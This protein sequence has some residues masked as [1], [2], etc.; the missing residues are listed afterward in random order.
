[1]IFG[2]S[3]LERRG[4]V[5]SVRNDTIN[6]NVNV[7]GNQAQN[8]LNDLRK[9]SAD[10]RLELEGLKKGTQAYIDK[11]KELKDV[12]AQQDALK[13]QIGLTAL[14]QKE[15]IQE[16][17]KLKA[18]KGSVIPFSN[19]FKDLQKQ[20]EK[21][22]NRLYDV[23][24]GVTGF[25]SS[26]SKIKDEVKQFGI[27]AAAYLGFE[28]ITNQFT[29]IIKGAG[30][31]SDSLA[32]IQRVTGMT[33]AEVKALN[34][35]LT[36]M[37]TRTSTEGLRNIA[38]VAGKLGVAKNDIYDFVKATDMLV[39]A[40]GDELGDA[41]QITTQLGKIINVFDK[42]DGKVTGEK[43]TS[44]GNA[45]VD[46]ANKGVA[47]GGFIVD[48][49]Q[50]LAGL[51]KTANLGLDAVMGLAAGLEESGQRSESSST[52]IIKVLS[53]IGGDVPK[54]AKVAGKSVEEFSKTLAEKPVEA[55]IQVSEGFTKGKK[56]F[57]DIS[58]AFADAGEDGAKIVSTLGVIG[59]KADWFR[60]KIDGTSD[61]LKNNSQITGAF[62]LK[63]QTL[64][65]T[66]DKLGKDFNKLVTSAAVTD[67]LKSAVNGVSEFIKWL[68]DLPQ[69]IEQNRTSLIV[70]TGVILTYVAAK[71]KATQASLLSRLA[72]ILE[73]AADK[74][75]AVQK[76]ALIIVTR[77][78]SYAKRVLAGDITLAAAAQRIWNAATAATGGI[79]GI[80]I[81]AITAAAAAYSFFASKVSELTAAQRV[82]AELQ[83]R[84]TDLTSD[85][86]AKA[87]SLFK[88]L[89]SSA[90]GYEAKKKLLQELIAINPEYLSGLNM[91]N[92]ATQKGAD[93]MKEYIKNLHE[94]NQEKARQAIIAEKE[95][96]LLETSSEVD[97]SDKNLKLKGHK[98]RL[99]MTWMDSLFDSF[100]SDV[101]TSTDGKAEI[102][103]L[104]D[105]LKILYDDSA[106]ALTDSM[107]KDAGYVDNA[108]KGVVASVARTIKTIK[109][110]ITALD[111]AY[112]T[113]DINNVAALKKNRDDRKKL[114]DELD[115]LEGKQ[116]KKTKAQKQG[117]GEYNQLKKEAE[118][119]KKDLIKLRNDVEANGLEG[120]KEEI[121]RLEDKYKELT[122]KAKKYFAAHITTK[123]EY[124]GQELELERLLD[125]EIDRIIKK[126]MGKQ[127]EAEYAESLKKSAE[128][129]DEQK[130]LAGRNYAAGLLDKKQYE[131][132]LNQLE[133]QEVDN[134]VIIAKDYSS[135]V[136]KA[137]ED[138]KT[139]TKEQEKLTT[140]NLIA[141]AEKR[142]EIIEQEKLAT[143]KNAVLT[144]RPNTDARLIADKAYLQAKF[145]LETQNMDKTSALYE[146]KWN[147]L[148]NSL[149]E[150]DKQHTL[151][152]IEEIMK[153]V[154]YFQDA[155]SSL[156][157]IISNK[158]NKALAEDR[159]RNDTKKKNYKGQL[160]GKLMSQAQYDKK[161]QAL[162]D[163][164]A[165]RE[166]EA[167]RKQAQ[168]EKAMA[169][170][171]AVINTAAAIAKTFVEFGWPLG[172]PMA[173]A[174]A[175]TGG[176]QVAAISS[177]PL[178]EMGTGGLLENGPY[179]K[180][181]DKGL[182]VV[183]PRTGKTEMLLEKDEA[184]MS[185]RAMKDARQ[186][187]VSGT[188]KQIS[189]AL[190]AL[191][192]GVNWA[193]GA[194]VQ[195]PKWR[196][197]RPANINPGVVRM[198]ARGGAVN[199]EQGTGNNEQRIMNNGAANG[200]GDLMAV[201]AEMRGLR[202]DMN[203]WKTKL[204]GEWVIKELDETRDLYDRAKKVSG[205]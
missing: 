178:P 110:Q 59:G 29:S 14:T 46:L 144:S 131:A 55:I 37:D 112:E 18:L 164:Q 95:K 126:R 196:T 23:R 7:N 1:M 155:L 159:K 157:T 168:R 35:E 52:A 11:S 31:L 123:A 86:E 119:Y 181:A 85:E 137:A 109:D 58:K 111:S 105:E 174:M 91:E 141:E 118:Q 180:D 30:K 77:T 189:S 78:Y 44:I 66:L 97:I 114:Q 34:A 129:F 69:W 122:A 41:D 182:H 82:Q 107:K 90:L 27:M 99:G 160:D 103:K 76:A 202:E 25:A 61:A 24:N 100:N 201:V 32:D 192:G 6:L 57:E 43:L 64:G 62:D 73:T 133:R 204:K 124:Q 56:G 117:D 187:T 185:G 169:I 53:Q 106:K 166:K 65:A 197:E 200:S 125:A 16:L 149:S 121:R 19:E 38:I 12:I 72:T 148:Y 186:Y 198:M 94:A 199:N 171:S 80:V 54:F 108:G 135:T 63:N 147:E 71:T 2:A 205:L 175:V 42:G 33:K 22:E 195:M 15:L 74:L 3:P 115:A 156:N 93:I 75:E 102:K 50:R 188:P 184:V 150:L 177:A 183:N 153:Y 8:Q 130:N 79:L 47:S 101:K 45:I 127:G 163:E 96:K 165:T 4:F 89:Q 60:G 68:K 98:N 17:N 48:F 92:I 170:F 134:R 10:I 194:V 51:A 84:I 70:L 167:R 190:N 67:F 145:D 162:D 193:G 21:V 142:K 152:K 28:F 138:V 36:A 5:M 172:I 49:T 120:D 158:E 179:H 146:E 113:I 139:F 104:N 81:L 20:I 143:A 161:V 9:K 13:K 128:F 39:V 173:A 176:L 83:K 191:N 87:Q 40:L 88:T 151:A 136:K 154:S 26:F 140:A 132:K 203:N 116:V